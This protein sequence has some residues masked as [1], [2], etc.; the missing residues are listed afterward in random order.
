MTMRVTKLAVAFLGLASLSA[1][2]SIKESHG[3]VAD[4]Q[5]TQAI[6]PGIDNKWCYAFDSGKVHPG[7]CPR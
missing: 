3:F 1:C 5:L 7:S 2:V 4:E 6:Q